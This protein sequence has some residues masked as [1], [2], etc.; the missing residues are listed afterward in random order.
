MQCGL[1]GRKLGH[2]Y[3]PE[4]H[5]YL[6]QYA[7]SLFEKEPEELEQFIRHGAY[8]GLNVTIPYKKAAVACCDTLSPVAQRLQAVNTIVRT[9]DGKICGHNTDFSGFSA[10]LK[11]TGLNVNGK[12]V[13]VLGSGGASVTVQSVLRDAGAAVTVVSRTGENNYDNLYLHADAALIVNATPVGMFPNAGASPVDLSLFPDLEGVL[14]LIYNPCRT[15]LLL[16]AQKRGLITE[17]GL[18]ML[19]AQ[20]K[21]SAQWFTGTE[22]PDDAVANI[23]R[24]LRRKCENLILIGMPG[25]GKSTVGK[26]LAEKLD[27]PFYDADR[28]IEASAG[29]PI[30]EIFASESESGFRIRESEV[31]R[32]LGAKRGI[33]IST[34]GGCV[35]RPE[36]Y[37]YLKQNGTIFRLTRDLSMLSTEDR[38]LSQTHS[39]KELFAARDPLYRAFADYT[40]SNDLS[41]ENTAAEIQKIL[42]QEVFYEDSCH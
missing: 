18:F 4:I 29:M 36:N 34:G 22:I 32:S 27:M 20:A 39:L 19:V 42:D 13:L 10:M 3:S 35:T 24:I 5:K 11:R 21:E 16:D 12:K 15:K 26:Y 31:L 17:N 25:C 28:Q 1:L 23:H 38:P 7:Y 37:E 8:D 9:A 41:P 14:D 33:V 6:G 30:P 40:V 2:S